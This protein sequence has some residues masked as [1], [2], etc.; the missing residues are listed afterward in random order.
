MRRGSIATPW[1]VLALGLAA[2]PGA[3]AARVAVGEQELELGGPPIVYVADAARATSSRCARSPAIRAQPCSRRPVR[4]WP[5]APAARRARP[6]GSSAGAMASP[7]SARS[8]ETATIVS[9]PRR[10][11]IRTSRRIRPRRRS[12][13]FR[14]RPATETTFCSAPTRAT[15]ASTAGPATT[16]SPRPSPAKSPDGRSAARS[17]ARA[18]IV[19]SAGRPPKTSP[20]V[21]AAMRSSR[22]RRRRRGRRRGPRLDR[23]RPGTRHRGGRGGPGRGAGRFRRRRARGPA[24]R[25]PARRRGGP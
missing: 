14:S 19:S 7:V 10:F 11:A 20:A 2:P 16:R 23:A 15:R 6:A 21:P 22:V 1:L 9:T 24:G 8:S 4:P 25:R 3:G 5:R 12:S 18:T 17:E 13:R